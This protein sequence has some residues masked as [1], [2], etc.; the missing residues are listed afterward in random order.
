MQYKWGEEKG[1]G[2]KAIEAN[3]KT[4]IIP[5]ELNYEWTWNLFEDGTAGKQFWTV[6]MGQMKQRTVLGPISKGQNNCP[7]GAKMLA[8]TLIIALIF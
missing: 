7:N 5:L 1:A 3:T 4:L 2:K 6:Q 8:I